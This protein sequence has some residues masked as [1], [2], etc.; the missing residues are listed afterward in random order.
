MHSRTNTT[1]DFSNCKAVG[2]KELASILGVGKNSAEKFG[3]EAGAKV[4]IGR[5]TIWNLSKIQ[6]H[7]N[8]MSN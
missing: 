8:A 1:I 6:A 3:N 7:L 2:T 4:K 5:R